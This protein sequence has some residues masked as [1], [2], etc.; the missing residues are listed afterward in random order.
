MWKNFC[1]GFLDGLMWL[2][3]AAMC[4]SMI[5]IGAAPI[6]LAL[7]YNNW[8]WMLCYIIIIPCGFGI[9]NIFDKL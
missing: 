9:Y 2:F 3:I 4:L 6:A 1:I 7:I 5:I 8:W